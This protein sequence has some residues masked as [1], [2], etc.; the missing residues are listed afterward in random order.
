MKLAT[1]QSR[2]QF[3]ESSAAAGLVAGWRGLDIRFAQN[4]R[5]HA[6]LEKSREQRTGTPAVCDGTDLFPESFTTD[7]KAIVYQSGGATP[8]GFVWRLDGSAPS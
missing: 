5:V 2:S 4:R 8:V 1:R 3:A 7:G 6:V